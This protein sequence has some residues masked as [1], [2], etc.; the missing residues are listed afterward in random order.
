MKCPNC[1][2]ELTHICDT[3]ELITPYKSSDEFFPLEIIVT[4]IKVYKCICGVIIK[5]PEMKH[6]RKEN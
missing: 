5:V 1:Q 2:E 3:D 6:Y 4:E